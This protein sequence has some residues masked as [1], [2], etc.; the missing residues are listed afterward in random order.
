MKQCEALTLASSYSAAH[1]CLKVRGIK[2]MGPLQLCSHH[3]SARLSARRLKP[4]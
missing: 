4:L 1:R 3:R 2:K